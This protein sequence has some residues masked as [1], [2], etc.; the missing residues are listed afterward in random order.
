MKGSKVF[1]PRCWKLITVQFVPNKQCDFLFE[2]REPMI[3]TQTKTVDCPNCG[4]SIE[5]IP[6]TVEDFLGEVEPHCCNCLKVLDEND[7]IL[8]LRTHEDAKPAEYKLEASLA[9]D[10]VY[11]KIKEE[12]PEKDHRYFFCS[13]HCYSEYLEKHGFAFKGTLAWIDE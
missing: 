10:K 6:Y 13:R 11:R 7:D 8:V 3:A 2:E 5:V 1:C 4:L 9:P 12:E